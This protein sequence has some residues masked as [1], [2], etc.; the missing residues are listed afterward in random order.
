MKRHPAA[1]TVPSEL[2]DKFV[3]ITLSLKVNRKFTFNLPMLIW[4]SRHE[5]TSNEATPPPFIANVSCTC[6]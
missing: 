6:N 1:I 4:L 5:K 2:L 3:L